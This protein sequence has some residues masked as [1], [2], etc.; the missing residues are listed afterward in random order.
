M[1]I[2]VVVRFLPS[3]TNA[4][5]NHDVYAAEYYCNGIFEFLMFSPVG[6]YTL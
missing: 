4:Y 2:V 6:I 5:N 3:I 1:C